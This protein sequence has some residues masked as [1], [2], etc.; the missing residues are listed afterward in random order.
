MAVRQDSPIPGLYVHV[1]FCAH[2]CEYCAFYSEAS[3]GETIQRYVGALCQELEWCASDL[4]PRTI[5][6][7]GGTPSILNLRQWEQILSTMQRLEPPRGQGVDDRI[8]SRDR[9]PGQGQIVEVIQRKSCFHG[10]AVP[11]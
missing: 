3:S 6:F 1:P 2:K 7:G 5:F 4:K 10:G 8:Q 11:G 9:F